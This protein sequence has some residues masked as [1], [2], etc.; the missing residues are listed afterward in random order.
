MEDVARLLLNSRQADKLLVSQNETGETAL[1][2]ACRTAGIG[3]EVIFNLAVKKGVDMRTFVNTADN[4]G[5]CV[6][7]LSFMLFLKS[8]CRTP[9]HHLLGNAL[10]PVPQDYSSAY[11]DDDEELNGYE[12]NVR[13]VRLRYVASTH[14]IDS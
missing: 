9:L 2:A 11:S 13:R 5:W 10:L 12:P 7:C 4:N 1:I 14:R 6:C 3:L 8:Y